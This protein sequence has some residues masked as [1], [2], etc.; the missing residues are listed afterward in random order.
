VRATLQSELCRADLLDLDD[1][2]VNGPQARALKGE[3][4]MSAPRRSNGYDT[5]G[6]G[7][8][9]GSSQPSKRTGYVAVGAGRGA[10]PV[11]PLPA[12]PD[13]PL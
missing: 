6:R 1:C 7:A 8:G 9:A 12:V 2:A 5:V 11:P 13:A 10:L 3:G 4:G